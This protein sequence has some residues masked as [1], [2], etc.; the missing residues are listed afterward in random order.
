M[1]RMISRKLPKKDGFINSKP[2]KSGYDK[3]KD[4]K[5]EER[6]EEKVL[7][8]ENITTLEKK[9][10]QKRKSEQVSPEERSERMKRLLEAKNRKN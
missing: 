8:S 3:L 5:G 9:K 6:M 2:L 10:P 7:H 4:Q 1:S